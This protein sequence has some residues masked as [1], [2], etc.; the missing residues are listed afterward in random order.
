M[1]NQWLRSPHSFSPYTRRLTPQHT[2]RKGCNLR[3]DR[4]AW[5][6]SRSFQILRN[7]EVIDLASLHVPRLS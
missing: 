2:H 6:A 4:P 5:K 1:L 3:L 7:A